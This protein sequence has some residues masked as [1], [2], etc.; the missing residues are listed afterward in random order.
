MPLQSGLSGLRS[1][2]RQRW[3]SLTS[4]ALFCVLL[5]CPHALDAATVE[6]DA[7]SVQI[8]VV[9]PA[10]STGAGGA[11][12]LARRDNADGAYSLAVPKDGVATVPV[13]PPGVYDISIE[14]PGAE[15]ARASFVIAPFE[16]VILTAEIATMGQGTS[17]VRVSRRE[18]RGEGPE[19]RARA[20][21]D[22]P[23]SDVWTL[24]ETAAPFVVADRFDTGGLGT[25]ASAL[26]G[27]RGES[28]A[29]TSVTFGDV[30]VR[31][32]GLTG[33]LA[34][35][36]D[37][38]VADAVVAT[39]GLAPVEESSSGVLVAIAT[40]QPGPTWK[41]AAQVSFSSPGMVGTNALV[42]APSIARLH[43][44]KDAGVVLGGPLGTGV[45]LVVSGAST[46]TEQTE[47]GRTTLLPANSSSLF[48]HLS[49]RRGERRRL[50]LQVGVQRVQHP[51]D[52]RRQFQDDVVSETG[53]FAQAQGT[54]ESFGIEGARRMVSVGAQRGAFSPSV[55]A[56]RVGGTVDRV[57]E[58]VVPA[59][60]A[61]VVS[62]QWNVRARIDAASRRFGG[63]VH[64]WRAG[65]TLEST[66]LASDILAM[67]VVAESVN[68]M[69]ARVWQ[70]VA[71]DVASRRVLNEASMF[72]G[73]RITLGA[74]LG[75]DVGLRAD[76]Q[77][78]SARGALR[79]ITWTTVSPRVAFRWGS[80]RLAAFGGYG[81]YLA[82]NPLNLLAFGDPGEVAF[83]VRRWLDVDGSGTFDTGEAGTLIANQGRSRSVATIEPGLRA[84]T[85]Q[86]WT[87]G[88]ET[89]PTAY[90][91]IRGAIIIRRQRDLVG[92]INVGVPLSSYRA[93]T[94]PDIGSD[95]GSAQDDQV[96]TIYGRLPQSYGQDAFLL[97][98]P[99]NAG[100][101]YDGIELSYAINA[102]RWFV[103]VGATA[104]RAL[105]LGGDL[106]AG[107]Y[108]NDQLVI[109]TRYAEPNASS[110]VPG[111]LFSD[112]AYVGKVSASYRAPGDI[113]LAAT[114]RYQDG[115][116]FTRLV[117]A[118]D[119]LAGP[120][121]VHAYQVGKTRFTYAGTIDARVEKSFTIGGRRLAIR[122]DV[123][124]LSNHRN[125]VEED[126]VSGPTFRLSTAVQPPITVRVGVRVDF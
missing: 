59:P 15:P 75:V 20:L 14:L 29:L 90:S 56:G 7:S 87:I 36:P 118:P 51:F 34:I 32:P 6:Q 81:R 67:P 21:E 94:V 16:S 97:T 27:S 50:G 100:V 9:G 13:V 96:L 117:I 33:R 1:P 110:N 78:G 65:L 63:A 95:E 42:A 25:G 82:G 55:D 93:Y 113:R 120:Y 11:I 8:R 123:F 126:V 72:I 5:L 62:S 99:E 46:R 47:R 41:G 30:Q 60:A 57:L 115:Q 122:A 54:W 69:P 106:G 68:G 124:N 58:G 83:E 102:P 70:P 48:A 111:R 104:Y 98:N 103:L 45:S 125:E 84:P 53:T 39:S 114:V 23:A 107:P 85:S 3:S 64:E 105:G 18:R 92:A 112:R 77:Y 49:A 10:P 86:E 108:E 88:A 121:V 4:F 80:A 12:L 91:V 35:A 61:A 28:W 101:D 116:P 66:R 109:G 89:R 71:P 73:D 37:L 2:F 31:R 22:L 26:L 43:A 52:D 40:R 44:W 74:G 79:G 17:V 24:L 119:I 76:A 19:F 38:L